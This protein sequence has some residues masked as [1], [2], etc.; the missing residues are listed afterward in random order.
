MPD[1]IT[2]CRRA[3]IRVIMITGDHPLTAL[4]IARKVGL[5]QQSVVTDP[6]RFVPVI[7]GAQIDGFSDEQLRR[8]LTPT[9]PGS[10]IRSLP[11]WR[12]P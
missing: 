4:A 3:G 9:A 8:L 12:P 6:G 1:A 11:A 10:R 2:T 7:E 5:A